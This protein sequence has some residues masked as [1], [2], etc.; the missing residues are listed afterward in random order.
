MSVLK[1]EGTT[2]ILYGKI[3]I[4]LGARSWSGYL[5]RPD[6]VGE[7]PTVVVVPGAWGLSGS[8][9][10]LCRRLARH[11]I[12]AI[13]TD[14]LRGKHSDPRTPLEDAGDVLAAIPLSR[15]LDDIAAF[16]RFVVNPS[17]DWSNAEHGYGV[18]GLDAGASW[19]ARH[20]A[21]HPLAI[22]LGVVDPVLRLLPEVF[23]D[24][25]V[26]I[27]GT[28]PRAGSSEWDD[29]FAAVRDAAGQAEWALYGDVASGF[30]DIG[31][32]D[33]DHVA[34]TDTFDRLVGFFGRTLPPKR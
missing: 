11:G 26:P 5:A 22:S 14:P 30:W 10:D 24:V 9:K 8:V 31:R 29:D 6:G 16:A 15:A 28:A 3:D 13:A 34:A 27:L 12:A 32:D 17:A 20:V 23:T 2:L 1:G 21:S 33:Y 4:P 19:A 7:W 25:A 18:V